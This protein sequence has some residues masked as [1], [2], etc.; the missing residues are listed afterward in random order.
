M[1]A[2]QGGVALATRKAD[3]LLHVTDIVRREYHDAAYAP[4]GSRCAP[5]APSL[6]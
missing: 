6:P 1:L 3:G 4:E 2:L 5:I